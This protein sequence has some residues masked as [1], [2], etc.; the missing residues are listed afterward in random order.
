M[1]NRNLPN[2]YPTNQTKILTTAARQTTITLENGTIIKNY[3]IKQHI[4]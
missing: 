4:C 1:K 3:D 2:Q